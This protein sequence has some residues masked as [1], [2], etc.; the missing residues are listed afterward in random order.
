MPLFGLSCHQKDGKI[1]GKLMG[2][3]KIYGKIYGKLVNLLNKCE[4]LIGLRMFKGK[5]AGKSNILREHLW[6]PVDFP[7]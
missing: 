2:L 1:Y 3:R 4:D 6:F 7:V 5:I